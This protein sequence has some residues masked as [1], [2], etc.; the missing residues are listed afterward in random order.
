MT[1][2]YGGDLW[3]QTAMLQP[4]VCSRIILNSLGLDAGRLMIS[5][6]RIKSTCC[7]AVIV[8][9]PLSTSLVVL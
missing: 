2:Q 3:R 7:F 8:H 1:T 5:F 6:Q 4:A 9:A